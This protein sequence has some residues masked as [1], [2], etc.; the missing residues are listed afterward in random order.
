MKDLNNCGCDMRF[1]AAL[2]HGAAHTKD[3][4]TWSRRGFLKSA[5]LLGVGTPLIM[6][7]SMVRPFM[8]SQ[9]SRMLRDIPTD[10]ILL[11]I[12]L[13]GGVDGLNMIVPLSTQ[14]YYDSRPD[15]ALG[16]AD[17]FALS[18]QW[19][20]NNN[21]ADLQDFWA[22]G[23]MSVI[24]GV[25]YEGSS[26]SHF[27]GTDIWNSGSPHFND[28]TGWIGRTLDFHHP[29]FDTNPPSAPL[30]V[31]IN[32][33]SSMLFNS[34][35]TNMG[36]TLRNPDEFYRIAQ[37]GGIYDVGDVPGDSHGDELAFIRQ[38]ANYTVQYSTEIKNA[39][40]AGSNAVSYPNSDIA[41]RLSIIA[42][43]IKGDLG[44]RIYKVQI[45]SFD[46]HATQITRMGTLFNELGSAIKA[47][48]DD[49][50]ADNLES[51]VLS[52]T[53]S[54]FGR[55][56]EQNASEGTDHGTASPQLI[57]GRGTVNGGMKGSDPDLSN[58]DSRGNL[59]ASTDFRH[60]Y[61]TV[62]TEWFGID[63]NATVSILDY[64][65]NHLELIDSPE[66]SAAS[67]TLPIELTSFSAIQLDG[68][69]IQ[70]DWQTQSELNNAGFEV[71]R[72]YLDAN[73]EVWTK[74]GFVEGAGTT[75]SSQNYRFETQVAGSG[76]YRFRLKQIDL[77]GTISYTNRI[78]LTVDL[79]EDFG[80]LE[81]YPN[82]VFN[83]ANIR[84]SVRKVQ[85]LSLK[86]YDGNGRLVRSVAPNGAADWEEMS[87][88]LDVSSLSSG[89][90]ILV[91]ESGKVIMSK[92]LIITK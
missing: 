62:M 70:L 35:E 25:G 41:E 20:M 32:S 15:I 39:A 92:Q 88:P 81:I 83:T 31:E 5:G 10:R 2:E 12:Q 3:H 67:C 58:P 21:L 40:D 73:R 27:R 18:G 43:L 61:G 1:G 4:Q 74:I 9:A 64:D 38:V 45:G 66:V 65:Y 87:F 23:D 46:T 34:P 53:Y 91:A 28:T 19:G 76:L 44:A 48:Y 60:I 16:A 84:V 13:Q 68:G 11:I 49:L 80:S 55:R 37:G 79:P 8:S 78:E 90:Y 57:I 77:N 30:A 75:N 22:Q 26:L 82:P 89:N 69:L 42:K 17:T 50:E 63:C 51:R 29:D 36:M 59:V 33:S 14:A 71:E 52:M 7:S 56:I 24:Q 86:L 6:G 85:D 72:L 54:E 47:F